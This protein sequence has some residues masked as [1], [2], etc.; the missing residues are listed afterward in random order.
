MQTNHTIVLSSKVILPILAGILVIGFAQFVFSEEIENSTFI[1]VNKEKF[2]QPQSRYS[3]QE[4]AIFGYIEDYSRGAQ[5]KFI[6]I[7][8]DE[9]QTEI[10]TYAA[11]NGEIYTPYHITNDSQIGIHK[12]VLKYHEKEITSTSFEIFK[13]Q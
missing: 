11:R 9:S 8:P 10:I 1:A 13:N 12:I 5:I 7:S 4:I 2:E 6:M 3:Y